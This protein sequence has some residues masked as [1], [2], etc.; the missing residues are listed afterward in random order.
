MIYGLDELYDEL[1]LEAKSIEE[2]KRILH[3]QFVDGKGVP[4][5]VFNGVFD[6]DPTRKKSYTKWTLMQWENSGKQIETALKHGTLKDLYKYFQERANTGLNLVSMPSFDAAFGKLPTNDPIFGPVSDEEASLPENDFDVVYESP[7][8]KI[9]VPHT[10]EADK[11]LGMGCKWCTA[12]AFGDS[13]H[14]FVHYTSYGPLWV[15]FDLRKPEVS[16]VDKKEYPY[17]RYQFCFEAKRGGELMDSRDVR[18]DVARMNIPEDVFEFYGKQNEEYLDALLYDKKEQEERI[19]YEQGRLSRGVLIKESERCGNLY[20][21][22]AYSPNFQPYDGTERYLYSSLD[23]TDPLFGWEIY[24]ANDYLMEDLG[25]FPCIYLKNKTNPSNRRQNSGTF[26]YESEGGRWEGAYCNDI[27]IQHVQDH[28]VVLE[29]FSRDLL[30]ISREKAYSFR[31]SNS[32]GA[33]LVGEMGN[34][35]FFQG[36]INYYH[37]PTTLFY[38]TTDT[39]EKVTVIQNDLPANGNKFEI[40]TKNGISYIKGMLHTY[41]LNWDNE[42]DNDID[43]SIF[44][45]YSNDYD[46]VIFKRPIAQTYGIF[47]KKNREIILDG[48]KGG[49]SFEGDEYA[50]VYQSNSDEYGRIYKLSERKYVTSLFNKMYRM[51]DGFIVGEKPMVGY[52]LFSCTW[53]KSWGPY[54][55]IKPLSFGINN[56]RYMF[57]VSIKY[58][59]GVRR[60][61]LVPPYGEMLPE[62]VH[63]I[64]PIEVCSDYFLLNHNTIYDIEKQ[65]I[66]LQDNSIRLNSAGY[67]RLF[68]QNVNEIRTEKGINFIWYYGLMLPF[69]AKDVTAINNTDSI[70][71]LRDDGGRTRLYLGSINRERDD[72]GN[73]AVNMAPKNGVI[74]DD[75]DNLSI[76]RWFDGVIRINFNYE[77]EYMFVW[78]S[79]KQGNFFAF[80]AD[81]NNSPN[82]QKIAR[83]FDINQLTPQNQI[84]SLLDRMKSL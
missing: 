67:Q 16:L 84:K 51:G 61:I 39:D 9:A 62:Y 65:E 36:N 52:Y 22:E 73:I 27:R 31:I 48:V 45:G 59:E 74:I 58:D 21:L 66:V 35:V 34:K 7:E 47:D 53:G 68:S 79:E 46:Y 75:L 29:G 37:H 70:K 12:G 54:Y 11:K 77:G 10:Y 25:D 80:L 32:I 43:I 76:Q 3:Y 13:D 6:I 82:A 44:G 38:I 28:I 20:L 56:S 83:R 64:Q 41:R 78:Y 14:Y 19:N 50:L 40:E 23:L 15:N 1:L 72:D 2:I 63:T 69:F 81:D 57:E 17:T 26:L 8:W 60:N 4:E 55:G 33:T 5:D 42:E 49:I 18:V 30:W 24:D 71:V